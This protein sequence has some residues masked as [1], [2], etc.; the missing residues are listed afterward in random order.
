MH[1]LGV[2][3]QL[4]L[5]QGLAMSARP[6]DRRARKST[7]WTSAEV[8]VCTHHW[9]PVDQIDPEHEMLFAQLGHALDGFSGSWRSRHC[10]PQQVPTH[11]T[12]RTLEARE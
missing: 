1:V 6:A 8:S 3:M 4:N 2:N 10:S 11:A 9:N 7:Q 12:C 5:F